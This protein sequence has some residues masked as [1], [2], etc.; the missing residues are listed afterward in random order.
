MEVGDWGVLDEG[1]SVGGIHERLEAKSTVQ[2]LE[3]VGMWSYVTDSGGS[4]SVVVPS[5]VLK[6]VLPQLDAVGA[7]P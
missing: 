5:V 7:L 1:L 6:G 4:G 3:V 2:S